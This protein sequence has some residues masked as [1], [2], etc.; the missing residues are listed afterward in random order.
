MVKQCIN[1][2]S[3]GSS[4]I[5]ECIGNRS[6]CINRCTGAAAW[7][8][9][10]R[11]I[12]E[13]INRLSNQLIIYLMP[14]LTSNYRS[15]RRV[16]SPG[17]DIDL[18]EENTLAHSLMTEEA[19]NAANSH[20]HWTKISADQRVQVNQ[21]STSEWEKITKA[22]THDDQLQSASINRSSINGCN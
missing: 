1:R 4:Y 21:V 16:H 6:T 12:I 13:W 17:G 10:R 3:G 19:A 5:Y 11:T 8:I 18:C 9:R 14:K 2:S 22:E 20:D 7:V 15:S